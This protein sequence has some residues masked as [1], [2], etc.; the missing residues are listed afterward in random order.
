MIH[1]YPSFPE[2]DARA[3]AAALSDALQ[4][5]MRS[6]QYV[7]GRQGEA[8]EREFAAWLGAGECIGVG[9]GTDALE[10]ILR[11]H[12][13]PAGSCVVVPSFAPSAVGTAVERA[14]LRLV[15]ADIEPKTFTLCPR[16]LERVLGLGL[17]VRAVIAVH[18][19]GHPV[20][21]DAMAV[22]C[23]RHG[24]L[25]IEDCAQAHGARWHG[26]LAGTLGAVAAFSFYP[27]KNLGALGDA[28][29]IVTCD[30]ALAQRLREARQYGWRERFVSAEAGVNSRLD[31][32]QAAV[33]RVKLKGLD[34]QLACRRE[35]ASVCS[36]VLWEAA[37]TVRA[38]CEHAWHQMV[39]RR[40]DRDDDVVRLREVGVP[41][42]VHYPKA[43]HQQP[44]FTHAQ[45]TPLPE[46]ESAA[47]EVLSLPFHPWLEPAAVLHAANSLLHSQ[48]A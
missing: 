14:G 35:L 27:T 17:P 15:L 21:W 30:A 28:G 47:S 1:A 46:S 38:G 40:Q 34:D 12:D 32:L 6:G 5:V 8:F 2:C 19:F 45:V 37:P 26:R 22:L 39:V 31:E 23:A 18:L 29:A 33:L 25:L 13:F 10:L 3:H 11:V 7:L 42:A 9:S 44:A 41:V 36:A 48:L 16:S 20:A 24:V 4:E 43:L